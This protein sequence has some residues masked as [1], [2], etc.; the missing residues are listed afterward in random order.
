MEKEVGNVELY[1]V[2]GRLPYYTFVVAFGN[3]RVLSFLTSKPTSSDQN[4]ISLPLSWWNPFPYMFF[5][6]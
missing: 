2:I 3:V 5:L 4:F 6:F 1:G